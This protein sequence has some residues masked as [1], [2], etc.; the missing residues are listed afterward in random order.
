M[1][2]LIGMILMV[3]ACGTQAGIY[4]C[5]VDG[6]TV[7]SQVP[8][9]PDAETVT[10][11]TTPA[12]T[13]LAKERAAKAAATDREIEINQTEREIR[14]CENKIEGYEVARDRE[15]AT[16]RAKKALANN[17]L[18]GATWEGSISEEMQAVASKWQSRIDGEQRR[19]EA[20]RA[21][22]DRLRAEP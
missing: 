3:C 21:K 13:G 14:R 7:F 18:A 15:L 4:K 12:N 2:P 11:K 10:V 1:R 16:L 8:C 20:L 9:A 22:A 19:I 6:K 17:N 5:V